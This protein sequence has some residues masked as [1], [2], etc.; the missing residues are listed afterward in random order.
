M[1]RYIV[2][3]QGG[4]QVREGREIGMLYSRSIIIIK[5]LYACTV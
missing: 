4:S 5:F 1:P 2:T 3:S